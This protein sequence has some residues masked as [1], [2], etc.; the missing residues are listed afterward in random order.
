MTDVIDNYQL[1]FQEKKDI[2]NTDR[3]L[4]AAWSNDFDPQ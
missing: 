2:I 1:L 3:Y 4:K